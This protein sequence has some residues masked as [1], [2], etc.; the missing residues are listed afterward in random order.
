M[1]LFAIIVVLLIYLILCKLVGKFAEVRGRAG[2]HWSIISFFISPLLG[3]LVLVLLDPKP[4]F[5]EQEKSFGPM[6]IMT[7]QSLVNEINNA[8]LLFQKGI[9]SES[10]FSAMKI[11]SILRIECSNIQ[12]DD[13]NFLAAF[14]P[15]LENRVISASE[16][17]KIKRLIKIN[18]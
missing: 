8:F 7:G 18:H 17:E 11:K 4:T 13:V 14:I 3:F 2:I 6:P 1:E 5:E 16:L 9:Y 10:E 15:L 12:E